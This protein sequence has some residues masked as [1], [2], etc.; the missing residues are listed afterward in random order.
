[1]K[2]GFNKSYADETICVTCGYPEIAHGSQA[3]C[4]AC[5]IEQECEFNTNDFKN[6]KKML[7]CASCIQKERDA[8]KL[9]VEERSKAH[10]QIKTSGDYY[11]ANIPAILEIKQA[12]EADNSIENK[13]AELAIAIK[14]R[15]AHLKNVLFEKRNE[16]S[17]LENEQRETL[18]YLNHLVKQLSA[19]KQKELGLLDINYKPGSG[20]DAKPK[21]PSIKKFNKEELRKVANMFGLDMGILQSVVVARKCSVE[22]AAKIYIQ[23]MNPKTKE[24]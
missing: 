4:E 17:T 3:T 12:I 13:P 7:L 16:V 19:E 22:E 1:M 9:I 6:P 5:G 20:K 18:I 21:A 11:N 15:L 10:E 2:H 14:S 8:N 24:N 23:T